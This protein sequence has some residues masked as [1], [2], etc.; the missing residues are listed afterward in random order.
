MSRL[1]V[2]R[3]CWR[4][5]DECTCEWSAWSSVSR[6]SKTQGC[7]VVRITTRVCTPLAEENHSAL[8]GPHPSVLV[9]L[10]KKKQL[11]LKP[12]KSSTSV[13]KLPLSPLLTPF[14]VSSPAC[15]PDAPPQGSEHTWPRSW[16]VCFLARKVWHEGLTGRKEELEAVS[17]SW[18]TNT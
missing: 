15:P 6:E 7:E 13:A 4:M 18:A 9:V 11:V 14:L 10:L 12:C 2:L 16:Q 1:W 3:G 5:F 8:C 17:T